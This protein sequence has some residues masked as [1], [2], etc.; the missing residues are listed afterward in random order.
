MNANI[1]ASKQ[2]DTAHDCSGL[3]TAH[4]VLHLAGSHVARRIG[5]VEGRRSGQAVCQRAIESKEHQYNVTRVD[6][7][8]ERQGVHAFKSTT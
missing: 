7:A 5:V 4:Q 6:Q 8:V 2:S 3:L 1:H